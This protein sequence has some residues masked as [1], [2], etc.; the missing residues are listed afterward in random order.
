MEVSSQ[1]HDYIIK[2][3][4]L[5]VPQLYNNIKEQQL[6]GFLHI[7]WHQVYYWAKKPKCGKTQ[8]IAKLFQHLKENRIQNVETILMDKDRG[9]MLAA[10]KTWTKSRIQLCYWHVLRAIKKKLSST[11]I[12]HNYYHAHEARSFCSII[13]PEWQPVHHNHAFASI[14]N[15][16]YLWSEWYHPEMWKLWAR[17]SDP[18]LNILRTTMA[19]E[20]HWRCITNWH[21]EFWLEW[22]NL[23]T[24]IINVNSIHITDSLHWI[25]SCQSFLLS[26]FYLCKHLVQFYG[27]IESEFFRKV[28][29]Q[30]YYPLLEVKNKN[31]FADLPENLHT[32][33]KSLNSYELIVRNEHE[34]NSQVNNQENSANQVHE[35]QEPIVVT[36]SDNQRLMDLEIADDNQDLILFQTR[37]KEILNLLDE[38]RNLLENNVSNS[39]KWL[40][41]IEKNFVPLR[42]LVD[43]CKRFER[44]SHIPNTWKNRNNNTFWL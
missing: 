5:T 6:D 30:E 24:R 27:P 25:C 37:K 28:T 31:A 17:A 38:T 15:Q 35:Q 32:I 14:A 33:I 20:S 39:N 36:N 16:A 13:N 42:K 44:Q 43:D 7:T 22:N 1:I 12:V 23:A 41:N 3:T 29:R 9:Q 10:H 19:I 4:L 34:D 2:N 21:E 26:R 11:G 40:D 8:A 18:K